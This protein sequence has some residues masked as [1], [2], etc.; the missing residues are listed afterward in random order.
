MFDLPLVT[1]SAVP[2]GRILEDVA[3]GPGLQ[4]EYAARAAEVVATRDV[5]ARA[6]HDPAARDAVTT[7]AAAVAHLVVSIRCLVDPRLV[8]LGGGLGSRVEIATAVRREVE[9]S[10]GRS[11]DLQVSRL[12]PRAATVGALGLAHFVASRVPGGS[13]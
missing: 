1:A 11:V 5:L 9:R 12:G 6:P 8:V 10:A 13:A 7:V 2:G 4:R 3:S